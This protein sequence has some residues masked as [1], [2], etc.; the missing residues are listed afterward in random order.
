MR[1][2]P[3]CIGLFSGFVVVI[4]IEYNFFALNLFSFSSVAIA[5]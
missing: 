3:G 4:D 2:T 5:E 1:W